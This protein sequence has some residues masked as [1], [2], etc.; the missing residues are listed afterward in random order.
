M[1]CSQCS[2][3]MRPFGVK[4]VDA[5]GT[6]PQGGRGLCSNC[7]QKQGRPV[8]QDDDSPAVLVRAVLR[9]STY[10]AFAR[11]AKELHLEVG[12]LLSR[13]AD[14]AVGT[15]PLPAPA[16]TVAPVEPTPKPTDERGGTRGRPVHVEDPIDRRIRTLNADGLTDTAIARA[17]GMS[18]PSVSRRR[19]LLGLQSPR[20]RGPNRKAA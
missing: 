6:V 3:K 15:A 12:D 11:H 20:P 7:A 19:R 8:D 18:Q 16:P 13:L 2:R 9:P 14:R 10:K 4:K 1:Q 17:V 5:P